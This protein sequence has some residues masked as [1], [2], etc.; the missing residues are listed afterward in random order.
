MKR[1]GLSLLLCIVP[2]FAGS[3]GLSGRPSIEPP[4]SLADRTSARSPSWSAPERYAAL[5]E[6]AAAAAGVPVWILAR[7]IEAESS[8]R[9]DVV[10]ENEDGSRDL[11]IAQLGERWM[12]D[13]VW[14]D[15]G[16]AAFDPFHPEEAIP[17]A[18]RYLARLYRASGDWRVA[19]AAYNCGL[20]RAKT[21]RIPAETAAY[22]ARVF[23]NRS[24][25]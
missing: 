15:N 3:G 14:F 12:G 25:E 24:D 4:A 9:P 17:V 7:T 18:A 11:G 16:A 19:V 23:D 1:R 8:W 10:G 13:F 22:V 2:A 21:G 6:G 5:V 20:S